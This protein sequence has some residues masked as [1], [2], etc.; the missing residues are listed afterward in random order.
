MSQDSS[1]HGRTE[2]IQRAAETQTPG[3]FGTGK[4]AWEPITALGGANGQNIYLTQ[5][6]SFYIAMGSCL[7]CMVW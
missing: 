3:K 1:P 6:R 5:T 4:D 7:T 2:G